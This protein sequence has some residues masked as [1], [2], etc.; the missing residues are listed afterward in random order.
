MLRILHLI[1]TSLLQVVLL[2]R[3]TAQEVTTFAALSGEAN[4]PT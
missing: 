2:A 3:P 4:E 1:D